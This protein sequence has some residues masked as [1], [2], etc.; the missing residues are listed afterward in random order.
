MGGE[1][2]EKVTEHEPVNASKV[3]TLFRS[4]AA[5]L[6]FLQ[7]CYGASGGRGVA[8]STALEI[9]KVGVPAVVAMQDQIGAGSADE[10]APSTRN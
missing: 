8:Y 10:S 3:E 2:A 4:Q 7:A 5:G 6:V 9:V 1:R